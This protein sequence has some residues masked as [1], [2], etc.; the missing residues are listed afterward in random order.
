MFLSTFFQMQDNLS[1]IYYLFICCLVN[2]FFQYNIYHKISNHLFNRY[3]FLQYLSNFLHLV[4]IE[5]FVQC[6]L[7]LAQPPIVSKSK[8][9]FGSM[10]PFQFIEMTNCKKTLKYCIFAALQTFIFVI[11]L[12]LNHSKLHLIR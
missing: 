11:W 12:Y 10:I 2:I 3:S 7:I 5:L 8:I 9:H 4:M 6:K 1:L